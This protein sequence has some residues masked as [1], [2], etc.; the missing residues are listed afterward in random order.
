MVNKIKY[1]DIASTRST[2]L[3]A[4]RGC[5][6]LCNEPI[7]PNKAVLDHDH[8]TG[9]IRSV[10]HR[11]CNAMLGKI[12]NSMSINQF[13][14]DRLQS[15]SLNLVKYITTQP[16]QLLLHPTYL[17]AEERSMKKKKGRGKGR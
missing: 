13:T 15:F 16:N 6:A 4:Q 5:C 2:L 12:E 14:I 1:K 11:G 17:T 8:K 10:L 3:A 9:H 7:E